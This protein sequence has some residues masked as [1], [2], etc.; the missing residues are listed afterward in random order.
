MADYVLEDLSNMPRA[1]EGR[2][3]ERQ[4]LTTPLLESRVAPHRVLE[5]GPVGLDAKARA[6]GGADRR[7][8]QHVVRED[9]VGGPQVAQ[10]IGI[11]LDVAAAFVLGE[12]LEQPRLEPV[13]LVEDEDGQQSARELR[14]NDARA[15]EVVQLG[16]RLLA[17]DGDVVPGAAP[18]ARERPRVDVRARPAE[19]VPVPEQDPH[20]P[21]R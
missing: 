17:D 21:A 16:V 6:G 14:S 9:E 7:A 11:R 18:L 2:L 20:A 3:R 15:S 10:R 8:H 12:V 1:D 19:Q 5:L 4:S 13:V